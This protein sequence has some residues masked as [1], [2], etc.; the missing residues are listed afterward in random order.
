MKL[1]E[2][3]SE[4]IVDFYKKLEA[5]IKK[6]TG[7]S[8]LPVT[9]EDIEASVEGDFCSL[10]NQIYQK[11]NYFTDEYLIKTDL[12]DTLFIEELLSKQ[13]DR[14]DFQALADKVNREL[15]KSE[16]IEIHLENKSKSNI[17]QDNTGYYR[18]I[19]AVG[20]D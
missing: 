2:T 5:D 14:L 12:I 15:M 19:K 10:M 20:N 9:A 11:E 3:I 8:V 4:N 17:V 7:E 13:I 6:D 1:Q 16:S 18:T